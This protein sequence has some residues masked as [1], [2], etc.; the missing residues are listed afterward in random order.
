MSVH[1]SS[2]KRPAGPVAPAALGVVTDSTAVAP[3]TLA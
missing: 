1:V 2:R 3:Y